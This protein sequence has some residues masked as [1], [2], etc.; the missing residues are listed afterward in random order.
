MNR[1]KHLNYTLEEN[2]SDKVCKNR[3]FSV[4]RGMEHSFPDRSRE[5]D[6]VAETL[7]T[8]SL[9]A[10]FSACTVLI[11]LYTT[12]ADV[13]H[14]LLWLFPHIQLLSHCKCMERSEVTKAKVEII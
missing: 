12:V 4:K 2:R 10:V 7:H 1:K 8:V 14:V 9:R 5:A 11:A 13:V 3:D 6:S